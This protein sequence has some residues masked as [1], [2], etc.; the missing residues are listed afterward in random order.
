LLL[1]AGAT[2]KQLARQVAYLKVENKILRGKLSARITV[3]A[4]EPNRL[5]RFG[6]KLGKSMYELVSIVH[7]DTLR[8]WP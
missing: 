1:I 3:T 2:S 4:Q 8:R 5:V 7:P 6:A